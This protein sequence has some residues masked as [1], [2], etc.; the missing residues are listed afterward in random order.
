MLIWGFHD[1]PNLGEKVQQLP[2]S[3]FKQFVK[4]QGEVNMEGLSFKTWPIASAMRP[5]LTPCLY[6]ILLMLA[7]DMPVSCTFYFL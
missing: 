3:N 1:F 4:D 2:V 6:V 7:R 5:P